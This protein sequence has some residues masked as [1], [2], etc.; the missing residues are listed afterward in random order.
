M[1]L[2]SSSIANC[3]ES[4]EVNTNELHSGNL[5]VCQLAA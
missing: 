2:E 3:T 1:S 5:F 4:S